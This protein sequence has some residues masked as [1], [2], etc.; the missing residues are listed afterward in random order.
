MSVGKTILQDPAGIIQQVALDAPAPFGSPSS[1]QPA[2]K[3]Q[4]QA[5]ALR[6]RELTATARNIVRRARWSR[7]FARYLRG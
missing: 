7:K 2:E 6:S 4:W 1:D 5:L 3:G